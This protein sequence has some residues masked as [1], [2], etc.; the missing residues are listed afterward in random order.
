[1]QYFVS[2]MSL[3]I[4]RAL[5]FAPNNSPVHAAPPRQ[6]CIP[7]S[8]SDSPNT[9]AGCLWC[10]H[11]T[12]P[13]T[14]HTISYASSKTTTSLD[15]GFVH[16][17]HVFTAKSCNTLNLF[18]FHFNRLHFQMFAFLTNT[19]RLFV[20]RVLYKVKISPLLVWVAETSNWTML[21]VID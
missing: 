16:G 12:C 21:S 5:S 7:S 18:N 9:S 14:D 4:P 17:R 2:T 3:F 11:I 1:M 20:V 6:P 13:V 15:S 8:P 10:S 19:S